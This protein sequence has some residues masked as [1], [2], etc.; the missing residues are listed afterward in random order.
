MA[1]DINCA[2]IGSG[3]FGIQAVRELT[4]RGMFVDWYSSDPKPGGIWQP[5]P[6]G[7]TRESTELVNPGWCIAPELRMKPTVT[8]HEFRALLK[9]WS[10][11]NLNRQRRRFLTRVDSVVEYDSHVCVATSQGEASYAFVVVATGHYGTPKIPTD[12]TG[13]NCYHASS[14]Q[15]LSR[16]QSGQSVLVVGGGQSGVEICE[17]IIEE[18]PDIR[19]SWC[20]GRRV[21]LITRHSL[22]AML[23]TCIRYSTR[24]EP[25][26]GFVITK[27][28]STV[29]ANCTMTSARVLKVDGNRVEFSDRSSQQFDHI[30]AATGYA[31][32]AGLGVAAPYS[33]I[34]KGM[35][36]SPRRRVAS[37]NYDGDGCGGASM[38]CARKQANTAARLFA[39]MRESTKS[40]A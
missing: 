38:R 31:S 15:D 19:L 24:G 8:V 3:L 21:R 40:P 34:T 20:T 5:M 25:P 11:E 30:I 7:K 2:V 39:G 32:P 4:R 6:W 23:G 10:D 35:R 9:S 27:S 22:L 18:R 13:N 1:T 29:S 14:L 33:A 37:L 16:I 17:E 12:W 28:P 36:L 26:R